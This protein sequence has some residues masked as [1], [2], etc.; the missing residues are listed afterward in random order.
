MKNP[1]SPRWQSDDPDVRLEAVQ[2]GK[3][4]QDVLQAIATQDP[5]LNIKD[6][7]INLIEDPA[8]LLTSRILNR[9]PVS[10]GQS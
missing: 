9:M 6:A 10:D 7:A 4:T 3:L 1:L 5:K 2:S 8:F